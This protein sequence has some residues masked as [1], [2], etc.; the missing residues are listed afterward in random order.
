MPAHESYRHFSRHRFFR[1]CSEAA[2]AALLPEFLLKGETFDGRPISQV[3]TEKPYVSITVDDGIDPDQV[4]LFLTLCQRYSTKCTAFPY[5]LAMTK[6]P[7]LW[8]EVYDERHEIGNHSHSHLNVSEST[9]S[10]I[11]RDFD[12]FESDDYPGVIGQPFPEP[13]LARVP[14]AQGPVNPDVQSVIRELHDLHVHWQLDSYSW[15]KGGRYSKAN[16]EYVLARMAEVKAGDII[17][18]HFVPLDM[19]ALP[20]ILDLL[21]QKGLVNVTFTKLWR[22]R[23]QIMKHK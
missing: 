3:D 5:G 2:Q 12:R 1:Y 4:E 10:A 18:L 13:G 19:T 16:L 15:K 20:W 9:R 17:I 11:L 14:F 22:N 6:N 7:N 8:R 23:K 21:S